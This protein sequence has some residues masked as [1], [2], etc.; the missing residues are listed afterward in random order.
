MKRSKSDG[1]NPYSP[2]IFF[3]ADLS[4]NDS[5]G[6]ANETLAIVVFP[7]GTGVPPVLSGRDGRDARAPWPS[8]ESLTN[9]SGCTQR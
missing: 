2:S 3:L 6:N 5:V 1:R 9:W 8:T 4:R 7:G